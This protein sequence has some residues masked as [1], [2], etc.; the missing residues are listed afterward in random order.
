MSYDNC[1]SAIQTAAGRELSDDEMTMMVQSLQARERYFKL[2]GLATDD[3]EASMM[4]AKELAEDYEMAAV[5]ERRNAAM[6][7]VKRVERVGFVQ[8]RFGDNFALGL[9]SILVGVN[10]AVE[11]AR[12]SVAQTQKSLIDRYMA[13][14]SYDLQATGHL[15]VFTSG[16]MDRDVSRALWAM[17]KTEETAILAGLPEAAV[18]IARVLNKWQELGRIEANEAGSWIRE[19]KGYIVKQ[20]HDRFKI[21][22]A[23]EVQ[24]KSDAMRFFDLER[25]GLTG[26]AP[27]F[28]LSKLYTDFAAGV[29]LKA[30]PEDEMA[31][32]KGPS[33]LA[34]KISQ[35]REVFFRDA[36]AW[37]DYNQMYGSGNVRESFV[38]GLRQR[39]MATGLMQVLGS[40]P[41]AMLRTLMTDLDDLASLRGDVNNREKLA[42]FSKPNGA[43]DTFLKAVDGRSDIAVNE[44]WARRGAVARSVETMA[45]LGGMIFSQLNDIAVFGSEARYQGRSFLS[46]MGE[47]V[48]GL[49][50]DLKSDERRELLASL[51]VAVDNIAGE[52]G[53]MGSLQE[54]GSMTKAMR[55][56]MKLNLSQ[57]WTEKF[58][59]SAALG[60]AHHLALKA[61]QGW[62]EVGDELQ[63]VMGLYGIGADEWDV[64]RSSSQRH[65]DGNAYITPELLRSVPQDR[66]EAY[67]AA[68]GLPVT[69][70]GILKAQRDMEAK[71]HT[72]F[73]DRTSFAALEPDA[74]T[75][76]YMLQGL[77]PG[78]VPGEFAR[79]MMQFK[80]FT[81]AYMQKI[82][83][84]ELYGRGYE[85]EGGWRGIAGALR[86]GNGEMQGLANIILWSTLA[87][88]GS[89]ALKDLAK[90]R[91]PRDPMDIKTWQAAML[92]GGGM[93]IWGDFL[94]G[95]ANRFGGKFTDLIVGPVPAAAGE[96]VD[97]YHKALAGDDV[98]ANSL[99][100]ALNHTPF[101]N[102]FYTRMALDYL[103]LYRM[104]EAVNPGY[105]RRMERR[106]EKDNAQTFLLRPSDVVR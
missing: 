100:V 102:L 19:A 103:V 93:G 72:Y 101:I 22:A 62:H 14:L 95:E 104:Q 51:G 79:F 6:N 77:Q 13:G 8:A 33:N 70:E 37:F 41:E 87:G 15:A 1:I 50:R 99:R 74:K 91:T 88:Y 49:G 2:K 55:F 30:I 83:G 56:F 17:G 54:P 89:M 48:T 76:A 105:L 42:E 21:K 3:R 45:K 47:A 86:N 97:L 64:I 35:T 85:G 24:W 75:K 28:I 78:T 43:A 40:N 38:G 57:W 66:L 63:R 92:Q 16:A 31:G 84:R 29:H 98:A 36:D 96:I 71:L 12:Q 67:L 18:S 106:V 81:G 59:A 10:R 46:G 80:S 26:E 25:M 7:M 27:D 52:L 34:K 5:I 73:T 32:F 11:G 69:D 39:A 68:K 53:A 9:E 82:M 4:A 60:M 61:S 20:S 58:R 65:V 90:G 23:G 44:I 94:F